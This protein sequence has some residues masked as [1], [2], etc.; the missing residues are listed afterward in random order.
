MSMA[1]QLFGKTVLQVTDL[2]GTVQREKRDVQQEL[3]STAEQF[4]GNE[5]LLVTDLEDVDETDQ[6]ADGVAETN[7]EEPLVTDLEDVVQTQ[8]N[9]FVEVGEQQ[10]CPLSEMKPKKK[11]KKNFV[12]K[13]TKKLLKV[14]KQSTKKLKKEKQQ[15]C[16]DVVPD[17]LAC[18]EYDIIKN[19]VCA[20]D[21]QEA[22]HEP[23]TKKTSEHKCK[24]Y[25][26]KMILRKALGVKK[27]NTKS[28]RTH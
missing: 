12:K 19:S 20:S 14:K 8:H 26:L 22:I 15:K 16:D 21:I 11:K 28:S 24:K 3:V 4:V 7:D 23:S 17:S 5:V 6:I 9:N 27:P 1:K 18:T 10:T 2:E 13:I 25:G